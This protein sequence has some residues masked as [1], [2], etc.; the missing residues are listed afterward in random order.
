MRKHLTFENNCRNFSLYYPDDY[1]NATELIDTGLFT[2]TAVY[3]DGSTLTYNDR[4]HI[5]HTEMR[6][7]C[8]SEHDCARAFRWRLEDQMLLAGLNQ[9]ELARATGISEHSISK[10]ARGEAV[11]SL[12]NAARIA[13]ALCCSLDD[14]ILD[15]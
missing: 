12:Y 4:T 14:L 9:K 8:E 13:K 2:V 10:Y 5:M 15:F 1:E 7:S 3:A 6:R 11:P